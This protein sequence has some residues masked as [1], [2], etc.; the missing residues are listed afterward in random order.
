M[1]LNHSPDEVPD[2][3]GNELGKAPGKPGKGP[4]KGP[5]EPGKGPGKGSPKG[6]PSQ[7]VNQFFL[8]KHLAKVRSLT[9]QP[10]ARARAR[11]QRPAE[12]SSQTWFPMFPAVSHQTERYFR[13]DLP[14]IV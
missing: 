3:P 9:G 4:G 5:G 13:K 14:V 1:A 12:Y 7:C 11:L 8:D 10:K 6:A 2:K